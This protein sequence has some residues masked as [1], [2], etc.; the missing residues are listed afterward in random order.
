MLFIVKKCVNLVC[1]SFYISGSPLGFDGTLGCCKEGLKVP[2]VIIN[3]TYLKIWIEMELWNKKGW[4]PL[5]YIVLMIDDIRSLQCTS[6]L[7]ILMMFSISLWQGSQ[8]RG[9]PDIFLQPA[10]VSKNWQ[11]YNFCSNLAHFR[12][13]L[14]L[15]GP[16][17]AF[18]PIN[19]G[20]RSSF[21]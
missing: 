19:C 17:N 13:F 20:P 18:F 9:P 4:E 21:S 8:T 3:P 1:S 16:Q 5:F 15:F 12:D 14:V 7:F 10:N 2:P 6:N 11:D